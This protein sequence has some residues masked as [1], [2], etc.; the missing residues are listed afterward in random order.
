MGDVI[1][2]ENRQSTG[3]A[4]ETP[5]ERRRHSGRAAE[6]GPR[7]PATSKYLNLVNATA[8]SAVLSEDALE[9]VHQA[10]LTVGEEI[11]MDIILPEARDRMKA[12]GAEVTPGTDRVRFDR[13]L[14]M[15]MLA[16]V[17]PRFTMHA[18]NPVRNVEIGGDD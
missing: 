13:G 5:V 8:R 17:P 2:L 15:E 14:I 16:S 3:A 10:S 11:G 7:A 6:H 1:K 12:A 18:R 9:A 4:G